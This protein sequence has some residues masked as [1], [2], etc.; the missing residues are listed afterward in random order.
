MP[1]LM[2]LYW[3]TSGVFPGEGDTSRF[4]FA[5]RVREAARA[6]F[7]GIGIWHTDLE[8]TAR[9][10]G[11]KEMRRIL[12]DHGLRYLEVEFL[13][14]WFVD[15]EKK[16]ESDKRKQLLLE[17]SAA[18]GAHHV[19]VG[20]FDC[21]PCE[22]P[23]LVEEFAAL[24]ADA[25]RVG[26]TVAFEPMPSSMIHSLP[27]C[28]RMVEEAAAP[29]GG[30]ALDI[31]HMTNLGISTGDIRRIPRGRLVCVELNDTTL[32]GSPRHDPARVRRFCGEGELDIRG[33]IRA[34]QDAGYRGPW[35]VEVFSP[36]LARLPLPDLSERAYQTTAAQFEPR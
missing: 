5:D 22:L 32:P 28:L 10:L 4:S 29:N 2:C 21:T 8:A 12:E 6:G 9:K 25:A 7:K 35:A 23:R 33:F 19:K 1:D 26:A 30:L 31:S 20:D 18:L 15:G 24:C 14:D 17:A 16:R 13:T 3:T 34:V 36:E 27:D 11:F